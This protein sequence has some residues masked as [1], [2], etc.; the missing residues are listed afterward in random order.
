MRFSKIVGYLIVGAI[1]GVLLVYILGWRKTPTIA[2]VDQETDNAS[3]IIRK[4]QVLKWESE[5]PFS[6]VWLGPG[7]GPCHDK[8]I[9]SHKSIFTGKETATCEVIRV[10]P[11]T[12]YF[13][14][15]GSNTRLGKSLGAAPPPCYGCSYNSDDLSRAVLQGLTTKAGNPNQVDVSCSGGVTSFD[16][17]QVPPGLK[18]QWFGND[19]VT[20]GAP[21]TFKNKDGSAAAVTCDSTSYTCTFPPGPASVYSMTYSINANGDGCGSNPAQGTL[22]APPQ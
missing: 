15:I 4:G 22:N 7:L 21:N 9:N 14:G 1:L 10:L 20:I 18:L 2:I 6:I 16:N 12:R 19:G 13:Y 8:T 3:F 11:H 5:T 17:S